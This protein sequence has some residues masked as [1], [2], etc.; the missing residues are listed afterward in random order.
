MDYQELYELWM[1]E[2][3]LMALQRIPADFYI[4]IDGQLAILNQKT[5]MKSADWGSLHQVVLKRMEFLRKDISQLRLSKILYAVT[6]NITL[7]EEFLTWGELKL[8]RDLTKS[9]KTVGFVNQDLTVSTEYS[10]GPEDYLNDLSIETHPLE[11]H[12]RSMVRILTDVEKIVGID[13]REYGPFS[14]NDVVSLPQDNA[15]AL[16][17]KGVARLIKTYINSVRET[18]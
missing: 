11:T 7:E 2:R 13:N 10:N 12:P 9:I 5:Q 14:E 15:N 17:S 6:H 8:L 1:N 3:T 4:V 18:E 16:I